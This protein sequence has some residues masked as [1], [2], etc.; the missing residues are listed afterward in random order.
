[1][2]PTFFVIGD[3]FLLEVLVQFRS[4]LPLQAV[5]IEAEQTFQTVTE[6]LGRIF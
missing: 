5:R 4:E 6:I 1:M 2:R 3:G